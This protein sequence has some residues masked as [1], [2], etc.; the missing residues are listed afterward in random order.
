ML[1][2]L[3]NTLAQS[4][5][6]HPVKLV[7]ILFRRF[8]ATPGTPTTLHGRLDSNCIFHASGLKIQNSNNDVNN[9]ISLKTSPFGQSRKLRL[10]L[11]TRAREASVPHASVGADSGYGELRSLRKQ[12]REWNEPYI[13]GVGP[14]TL[15]VIPDSTQIEEPG[16]RSGIGRP[17]TEPRYPE[18][19]TPQSPTEI[20]ADLENDDWTEVTWTEGTKEPL[21]G[22]FFR[23]RV[24]VVKRVRKRWV[25]EETGWL[26][27][28]DAP[29]KLRAWLCWGV[30]EWSLE[31]LVKYANLRWA[32]EQFHKDAKQVLGV[33]QFE[34]RSRK[35]WH[36]H[37]TIVMLTYAF[38]ATERAA[39]GAAARRPPFPAI[40]RELVYEMAPQIAENEGLERSK[41]REV[42]ASMVRG[43][44]DW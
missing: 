19:V 43:L 6:S 23:T 32:I 10:T 22:R 37:V 11:L 27:V 4:A 30:N 9:V 26:L 15:H 14:K 40:A 39:Q 42:G 28:E 34:G 29:D 24:R 16:R 1:A 36:H 17:P 38:I 31:D 5:K 44:T 33:D 3:N 35:G 12:L 25:S 41:A 18:D 7:L 8:R 2:S 21:S 20:A 13:L